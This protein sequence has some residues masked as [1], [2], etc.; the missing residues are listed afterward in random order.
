MNTNLGWF[1]EN[2]SGEKIKGWFDDGKHW[3]YFDETTGKRLSGWQKDDN[4]WYYL[5]EDGSMHTGWL[6]D[7][8]S[9]YFLDTTSGEMITG[10]KEINGKWYWFNDNGTAMKGWYKDS[11]DEHWYFFDIINCDMKTGWVQYNNRWYYLIPESNPSAGEYKGQMV[12]GCT[13]IIDGKEYKF[14]DSGVWEEESNLTNHKIDKLVD[15]VKSY[16]G[17]YDHHYKCPA[18]VDT[19][20]Y[21]TTTGW[22][23]NLKTCTEAQATAA[24]KEDLT[25]FS[26]EIRNR[27]DHDGVAVNTDEFNAL[28]SFAY[29]CGSSAL[30]G[31]TLY[32]NIKN[33]N[34]SDLYNNFTAWCYGGGK[35][36][37]GL[38][39]RRI[40]EYEM[41]TKGDYVRDR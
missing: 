35:K 26:I 22:L 36:L 11:N 39:N 38:L 8:D 18:G 14:N 20:G 40:E 30:F 13:R 16:E 24:L 29:N 23:M 27:L 10:W 7:N 5:D 41:F 9:W 28:V 6:Q 15:F 3:Y 32:R 21:G 19:I 34:R 25:R 2:E 37:P 31:S 12:S 1:L 33:G 4:K 17:F